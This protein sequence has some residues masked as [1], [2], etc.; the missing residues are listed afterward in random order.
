M[1]IWSECP[2]LLVEDDD[3]TTTV[4]K[5]LFEE[6]G[7]TQVDT[8]T[9]GIDAWTRI[10]AKRYG[11]I[12]SDIEM[13][14]VDGISFSQTVRAGPMNSSAKFVVITAS[15]D[16]QVAFQAGVCGADAFLQKPITRDLLARTMS[17]LFG[18]AGPREAA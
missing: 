14:P 15:S 9:D 12:A 4:L 6:L 13:K 17:A 8:A 5:A 10:S 3:L 7:F 16:P 11:L 2:V 1:T 18:D